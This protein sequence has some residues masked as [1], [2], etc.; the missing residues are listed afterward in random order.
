ML[1]YESLHLKNWVL[2][3]EGEIGLCDAGLSVIGG[4]NHTIKGIR[5]NGAG[6]SLLLSAIPNLWY[7]SGPSTV[8][9]RGAK[10]DTFYRKD[11][12]I[13]LRMQYDGRDLDV[14]KISCKNV[15]RYDIKEDGED[16]GFSTAKAAEDWLS[17]IVPSE[18]RFYTTVYLDSRR[19]MPLLTASGHNR[20]QIFSDL[21][22]LSLYDTMKA[23]LDTRRTEMKGVLAA[24]KRMEQDTCELRERMRDVQKQLEGRDRAWLRKH[25]KAY[26][27]AQSDL[28][29]V[30]RLVRIR[31]ALLSKGSL[32][33]MDRTG[34]MRKEYDDLVRSKT[35]YDEYAATVE[36]RGRRLAK[37]EGIRKILSGIPPPGDG[38]Q[39]TLRKV[40]AKHVKARKRLSVMRDMRAP[41]RVGSKRVERM[42]AD[43]QDVRRDMERTDMLLQA[44]RMAEQGECPV[45]GS[46]FL[47]TP[48]HRKRAEKRMARLRKS[49]QGLER[50]L[51]VLCSARDEW[52]SYVA[53]KKKM[54]RTIR[55]CE[56]DV[57]SDS[58]YERMRQRLESLQERKR[59]K[60]DLSQKVSAVPS[61][62]KSI[63][64][65]IDPAP[66]LKAAGERM[67]RARQAEKWSTFLE[68]CRQAGVKKG[69]EKGRLERLLQP[70]HVDAMESSMLQ[71]RG[72]LDV[73]EETRTRLSKLEKDL[74]L[75][76]KQAKQAALVD[77]LCTAY[78][79]TGLK[80]M[81]C[82]NLAA[83]VEA[84]LNTCS[85]TLFDAYKFHFDVTQKDFRILFEDRRGA[86][87]VR[88]LSGAESRCFTVLSMLAILPL[89][90]SS[91]RCNVLV[92][93]EMDVNLDHALQDRYCNL[94]LPELQAVVPHVL[95]VTPFP[96]RYPEGRHVT[97]ERRNGTS[98]I[99]L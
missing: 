19:P 7:G 83:K 12:S 97:V 62:P 3:D 92:L 79:S 41:E 13:R 1:Q 73:L 46:D 75:L 59:L 54:D 69:H 85:H 25:V 27:K 9:R 8:T 22:D 34:D 28:S 71:T 49:V 96:E 76:E 23:A 30:R 45:C 33:R 86:F 58:D 14:S 94:F 77:A 91:A 68:E 17:S 50:D 98:H 20:F 60:A 80:R 16:K 51:A 42:K 21:F 6:K 70:E 5:S 26:R 43:I 53:R 56:A 84:S 74:A 52:V 29:N 38:E 90:P 63:P 11:S 10:R 72:L 89:L 55:S 87:D 36:E 65:A 37:V 44:M 24:K 18:E 57:L 31:D 35:L 32:V 82:M 66:L 67:E 61:L 47:S 64:P 93:D 88:H 78:G 95:V 48:K 81:A 39:R 40:L 15:L 99:T 2:F 4:R